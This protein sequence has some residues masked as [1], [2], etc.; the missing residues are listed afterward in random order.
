MHI[1]INISKSLQKQKH[2]DVALSY[3]FIK[4]LLRT[5]HNNSRWIISI[6]STFFGKEKKE[7][8]LIWIDI[9]NRNRY[10]IEHKI[11]NINMLEFLLYQMNSIDCNIKNSV[12]NYITEPFRFI[13]EDILLIHLIQ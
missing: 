4:R 10:Y 12:M 2:A 5:K 11:L 7:M 3:A 1:V 8:F 6:C 13:G 9:V